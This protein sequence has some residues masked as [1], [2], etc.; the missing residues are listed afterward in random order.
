MERQKGLV[1]NRYTLHQKRFT[2]WAIRIQIRSKQFQCIADFVKE[3]V[4]V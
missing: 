3:N 1:T 4:T 2:H